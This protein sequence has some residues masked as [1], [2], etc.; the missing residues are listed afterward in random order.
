MRL[1]ADPSSPYWLG[2][3]V[4]ATATVHVNGEEQRFVIEASEEDGWAEVVV[5]DN[6]RVVLDGYRVVTQRLYGAVTINVP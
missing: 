1:S 2:P 5:R 4:N 3:D 6:D